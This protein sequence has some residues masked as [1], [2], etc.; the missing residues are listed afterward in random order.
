M[1]FPKIHFAIL[2]FGFV[3][4]HQADKPGQNGKK[5]HATRQIIAYIICPFYVI[6]RADLVFCELD[7]DT[8]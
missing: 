8:R 1:Y 4:T 5:E 7:S 2:F 3:E 6:I